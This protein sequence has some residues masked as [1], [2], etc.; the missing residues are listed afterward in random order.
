MRGDDG[1]AC[2]PLHRFNLISAFATQTD[3]SLST[4][5]I[6]SHSSFPCIAFVSV[7]MRTNFSRFSC[8]NSDT[9]KA[10]LWSHALK[11]GLPVFLIWRA[12]NFCFALLSICSAVCSLCYTE[13]RSLQ[14]HFKRCFFLCNFFVSCLEV[15]SVHSCPISNH[16]R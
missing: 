13:S 10:H 12:L 16:L 2:K 7:L 3:I 9:L 15:M 5:Q 4:L 11:I 6:T 8:T 14:N 1:G